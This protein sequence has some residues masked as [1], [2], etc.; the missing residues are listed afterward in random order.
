MEYPNPIYNKQDH[1][2]L[3]IIYL[4]ILTVTQYCFS[5]MFFKCVFQSILVEIK[6]IDIIHKLIL[7]C[8]SHDVP[9]RTDWFTSCTYRDRNYATA[10]NLDSMMRVDITVWKKTEKLKVCY[11][12]IPWKWKVEKNL[13]LISILIIIFFFLAIFLKS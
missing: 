8:K 2:K 6:L 1:N 10:S 13:N 9:N 4:L 11:I 3:T 12:S 7:K 5:V